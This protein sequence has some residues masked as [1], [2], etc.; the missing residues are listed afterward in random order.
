MAGLVPFNKKKSELMNFGID[1]F[2]NALDDFFTDNWPFRKGFA[3]D[4][5]KVDI[6]EDDKSYFVTAD[7]PGVKKEELSITIDGGKLCIS[8]ARE[9]KTEDEKK[10]YVH[11][12]R[13]YSSMRRNI[14]LEDAA[15]DGVTAKLDNGVLS[16]TVPKKEKQDT[17]VKVEV[18]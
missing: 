8:V 6:Q 17:S 1:D 5:F 7:L 2:Y 14:M 12:E 3:A 10:N 18:K 13:R 15:A 9:E 4:T 16:V 11:K